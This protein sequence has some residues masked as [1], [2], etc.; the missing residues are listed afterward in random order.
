L[1]CSF[2]GFYCHILKLSD[3]LLTCVHSTNEP[4]RHSLF[5]LGFFFFFFSS[6]GA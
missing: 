2:G 6:I 4:I 3:C 5:L 1:L